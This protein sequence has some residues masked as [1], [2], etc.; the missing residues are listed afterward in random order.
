ML[1]FSSIPDD[2]LL[3]IFAYLPAQ[4]ILRSRRVCRRILAVTNERFVWDRVLWRTDAPLPNDIRPL[5]TPVTDLEKALA[6]AERM[7]KIWSGKHIPM[8]RVIQHTKAFDSNTECRGTMNPYVIFA[9]TGAMHGGGERSRYTWYDLGNL[10]KPVFEYRAP[11]R[12]VHGQA[13]CF[14]IVDDNLAYVMCV[15]WVVRSK[16]IE[17]G[18]PHQLLVNNLLSF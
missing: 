17:S 12:L 2:I 13:H 6:R 8:P 18:H 7:D 10:Q 4:D 15:S 9:T 16:A 11:K 3:E 5:H 14:D 1:D